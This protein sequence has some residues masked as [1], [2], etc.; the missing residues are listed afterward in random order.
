M[1]KANVNIVSIWN[2]KLLNIGRINRKTEKKKMIKYIYGIKETQCVDILLVYN[3][4]P[5][6]E[7]KT[8]NDCCV[9][10]ENNLYVHRSSKTILLFHSINNHWSKND[11][12]W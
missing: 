4:K 6:A 9:K 10:N 5:E 8:S 11:S 2:S 3:I 12:I 1:I 7:I